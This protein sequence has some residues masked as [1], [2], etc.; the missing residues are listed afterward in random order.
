M[1]TADDVARNFWNER[2]LNLDDVQAYKCGKCGAV[3]SMLVVYPGAIAPPRVQLTFKCQH[4]TFGLKERGSWWIRK[5][6]KE[7]KTT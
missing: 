1:S 2:F 4:T 7:R 3:L 6:T 5:L